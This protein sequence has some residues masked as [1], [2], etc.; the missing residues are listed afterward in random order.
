MPAEV[1][2]TI[3]LLNDAPDLQFQ[4]RDHQLPE[5]D[6]CDTKLELIRPRIIWNLTVLV[7][8]NKSCIRS[9]AR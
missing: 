6:T 7:C 4:Y 8:D 9:S 5:D 3:Y 1:I 2:E